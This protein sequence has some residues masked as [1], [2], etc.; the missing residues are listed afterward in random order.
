DPSLAEVTFAVEPALQGQGIGTRLLERMDEIARARGIATF[1]ALAPGPNPRMLD[2]F[3]NCGFAMERRARPDG[4][5]IVASLAVTPA[6]EERAADRS[7]HAAAASMAR[8][9]EPRSV[10]IIGASRERGK[11]GADIL[12]NVV[13]AGF[14]G[15]IFPVNPSAAEI[16]G[17]R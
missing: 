9:F 4:D 11:I 16:E 5:R 13:G 2:V 6:S 14:R 10:A 17:L 3:A 1:E 7:E 12:H 15:P 8:L